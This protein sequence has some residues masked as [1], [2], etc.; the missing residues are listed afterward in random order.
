MIMPDS[1]APEPM[2]YA[3]LGE[4]SSDTPEKLAK[5]TGVV[6]WSYLRPHFQREALFF[7]DPSLK[8]EDVGAAFAA[9]DKDR[10][11]AWLKSADLVKISDLHAQQWEKQK[12]A[13]FEA[14][15]VSPFV[16]CRPLQL[17]TA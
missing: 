9:N 14:L 16:L 10:V 2:K 13:L 5:Y 17:T 4:D 12:D 8:L 3:I 11:E 15:V 1:P 6:D 7:V